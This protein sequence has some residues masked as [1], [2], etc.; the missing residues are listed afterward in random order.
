MRTLMVLAV[1]MAFGKGCLL[2]DHLYDW[3]VSVYP[4]VLSTVRQND[5]KSDSGKSSYWFNEPWLNAK[6]LPH[7]GQVLENFPTT[8]CVALLEGDTRKNLG[9]LPLHSLTMDPSCQLAVY[10]PGNILYNEQVT[11]GKVPLRPMRSPINVWMWRGCSWTSVTSSQWSETWISIYSVREFFWM[12]F[13][14]CGV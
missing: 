1:Y 4:P 14:T 10:T 5:K 13:L 12:D 2:R 3:R 11:I 7:E 6:G 8:E 9:A